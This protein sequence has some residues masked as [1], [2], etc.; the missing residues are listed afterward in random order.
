M[1]EFSN[2]ANLCNI[3][4]DGVNISRGKFV[5]CGWSCKVFVEVMMTFSARATV[6]NYQH[7]AAQSELNQVYQYCRGRGS[8]KVFVNIPSGWHE[9]DGYPFHNK[10][11]EM[12]RYPRHRRDT[13]EPLNIRCE[14]ATLNLNWQ[15]QNPGSFLFLPVQKSEPLIVFL[16]DPPIPIASLL[17]LTKGLLFLTK[18]T[19]E[20]RD[21]RFIPQPE[22]TGP[23][24]G[25]LARQ[26]LLATKGQT[27]LWIQ[28]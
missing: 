27:L 3:A 17:L 1:S 5:G 26:T 21:F 28:I 15:I 6:G 4:T 8:L 25:V 16:C 13:S 14:T 18:Y 12:I 10:P 11:W 9:N 20:I 7:I 23:R 22:E 24:T 2:L 19:E